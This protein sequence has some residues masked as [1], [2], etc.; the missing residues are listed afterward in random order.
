MEIKNPQYFGQLLHKKGFEKWARYMFKVIEGRPFIIEP[1]H[2]DLFAIYQ[3]LY[4]RTILRTNIN[5]PPRSA[6]TTLAKYFIAYTWATNKKANFIY[7]SFSQPLLN[8]ISRELASILQHP[9]YQAMYKG[10]HTKETLES[11]PVN[12]FWKEFLLEKEAKDSFTSSKITMAEG[13]TA[14]FASVGSAIIGL[15]VGVRSSKEFAGMLIIDDI[16]KPSEIHS[17]LMREKTKQYYS[18]TLLTRL[19]DSNTPVCNIQQRLHLEDLS[20][21]LIK[22]YGFKTLKKPLL[23]DGVCQL[24]SQYNEDRIRELRQAEST[25]SAQYQQEPVLEGGNLFKKE[26]FTKGKV[27]ENYDY[28]FMTADLAY[29][30]KQS[31]DY[32]VFSYW[33]VK[34]VK[35]NEIERDNLYLIECKRKKI[36]A[37]EVEMW[38]NDWIK[39]KLGYSFRY[40]WIEDKSHGIY[41]N[42]KYRKIGIPVP[43]E[44]TLKE[45]LPRD[46]D[47]VMRANNILPC[48]NYINPNLILNENIEGIDDLIAELLA[49]PNSQ[50]DDFV[51][52]LIDAVKIGLFK[53]DIVSIWE[54]II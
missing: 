18:D 48:L 4:N 27:L 39:S 17:Q 11:K 46:G 33:G 16:N 42:Q 30:D 45:T 36:E 22:T 35:V 53:D 51:D 29:K 47:K 21:W 28:R 2:A 37:V 8:S 26:L 7:T 1:L 9:I 43:N 3:D 54:K 5:V 38:I 20:G 50:N 19:N 32:S 24:P 13:G 10:T 6:K 52:T 14:L 12:D 40:V 31:N 41:L 25:F 23:V 49:F 34:K 15:G 44:K